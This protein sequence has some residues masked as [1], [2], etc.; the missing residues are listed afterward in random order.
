[1]KLLGLICF[2]QIVLLLVRKEVNYFTFLS[3]ISMLF[4]LFFIVNNISALKI[5]TLRK[6]NSQIVL[7]YGSLL[8]V[9][10]VELTLYELNGFNVTLNADFVSPTAVSNRANSIFSEPSVYAIAISIMMF[11]HMLGVKVGIWKVN[12]KIIYLYGIQLILIGSLSGYLFA[13]LITLINK[14]YKI[15][16]FSAF[17][18]YMLLFERIHAVFNMT[19]GSALFR[20]MRPLSMISLW[21]DEFNG[22]GLGLNQYVSWLLNMEE[23]PSY[24]Y[25]KIDTIGVENIWS[26]ILVENGLFFVFALWFLFG[27]SLIR[28]VDVLAFAILL[29]FS[30]GRLYNLLPWIGLALLLRLKKE[31]DL[32][33]YL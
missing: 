28:N 23:R 12:W 11:Y 6:F 26:I 1:M 27:K 3:G 30:Y 29:G 20:L 17:I 4:L 8:G 10:L 19:D 31:N 14:N 5:Q 21:L 18:F 9:S 13:I 7:I 32:Y 15:I 25:N 16:L 2:N 24:F 33:S 22:L